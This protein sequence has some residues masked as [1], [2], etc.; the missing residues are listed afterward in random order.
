[1]KLEEW[2]EEEIKLAIEHEKEG[3]TEND[4]KLLDYVSACYISAL[5]AFKSLCEDGHS[6]MSIRFTQN[7]L[8]RLIDQKPLTSINGDDDE[9]ELSEG[10]DDAKKH[11]QNKRVSSLFKTVDENGDTT[12]RDVDR[13][14]C[15]NIDSDET[16]YH[17]GLVSSMI[18]DM[19]PITMPYYPPSKPYRVTCQ[20]FLFDKLEGDFDTFGIL[21]II[22]PDDEVINVNKYFRTCKDKWIEIVED[23]YKYR[24]NHREG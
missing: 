15:V 6:G 11:Y 7:I 23:D 9:W 24:Y 20:Q 14:Y 17:M 1:M 19:Y 4:D 10:W 12:Y 5:K 18:D 8:N 3:A 2:A 22:T 13:T 21:T 16:F